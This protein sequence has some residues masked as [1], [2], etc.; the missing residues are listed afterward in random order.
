MVDRNATVDVTSRSMSER[1]PERRQLTI[2]FCDLVNST[3]LAEGLDP[4]DYASLLVRYRKLCTTVVERAGGVI[5]NAFGDGLLIYFGYPTASDTAASNALGA[6]LEIVAA[7][8][9]D[10]PS[11][12]TPD[13]AELAVRIGIHTGVVVIA[14]ALDELSVEPMTIFGSAPSIAARVQAEASPNSV[15]LSEATFQLSGGRV[16]CRELGVRHLRGVATPLRL[17]EVSAPAADAPAHTRSARS[18]SPLVGRRREQEWLTQRWSDVAAGTGRVLLLIGEPGIGKSH[19]GERFLEDVH[20]RHGRRLFARGS[21]HARHTAFAPLADMFRR[22]FLSSGREAERA[23]EAD[24]LVSRLAARNAPA[25]DLIAF[26]SLLALDVPPHL[27]AGGDRHRLNTLTVRALVRWLTE[28]ARQTPLALVVEDLHWADASTREVVT[29]LVQVAPRAPLLVLLTSRENIAELPADVERRTLRPLELAEARSL[30]MMQDGASALPSA[31]QDAILHRAAGNPLFIEELAKALHVG[32]AGALQGG[33]ALLAPEIPPTLRDTLTAR[34]DR[35]GAHKRVAQVA[36]VLGQRFTLALLEAMWE[37]PVPS[38]REGLEE[39]LRAELLVRAG[40][41]AE[42]AYA[43]R[44]ALIV[45]A[46]YASLL[47]RDRRRHHARAADALR[48]RSGGD[49]DFRPEQVAWHLSG[50]GQSE[51]AFEAWLAAAKASSERSAHAEATSQL[52]RAE[53]E[54]AK[55]PGADA[56]AHAERRLRMKLA[57]APVLIAR[58]GWAAPEVESAYR[59]ALTACDALDAPPKTRFAALRGL[60]NVYLLRGNLL[61]AQDI[62]QQ[63]KQL[64]TDAADPDLIVDA[65]RLPGVCRFLEADFEGAVRHLETVIR[66][67]DHEEMS[68]TTQQHGLQQMAVTSAWRAWSAWFQGD[69]E[70]VAPR[71]DEAAR[72]AREHQFS[73]A[74]VL[75]FAATA[76]QFDGDAERVLEWGASARRV[77]DEHGF[78]YWQAWA[79]I[80]TGWARSQRGEPAAGITLLKTG[81]ESYAG[82]GAAQMRG[83]WLCLLADACLGAWRPAEARTASEAAIAEA[84]RTGIGF[85]RPEAYRLL[86]EACLAQDEDR[87]AGRRALVSAVELALR[88][89]SPV[90][91]W[92]A[93]EATV[94]HGMGEAIEPL[95][96]R[97]TS[98]RGSRPSSNP[99]VARA[100]ASLHSRTSP[101]RPIG[102]R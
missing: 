98:D 101:A 28:E 74:Y 66:A 97:A 47:K 75:C 1:P 19:L 39:L 84:E 7:V 94:R 83:L 10:E 8:R 50:S 3:E 21:A 2:M 60:S 96:R 18:G 57:S 90:L 11:D 55:L 52:H 76:A 72:L 53:A 17:Y 20:A 89:G 26:A 41:A 25:E 22:E 71:L 44:H 16:P 102:S 70:T 82:L 99:T 30:L 92:K 78:A 9:G 65:H 59:A 12:S 100:L 43:F 31:T 40:T 61:E 95:L 81:M 58:K 38:L 37:G 42:P 4:E 73:R 33:E 56:A 80:V 85:F 46:A 77:A 51:A 63:I 23:A 87:D 88:Q 32:S 69:C 68:G 79:D 45:E 49:A 64:A 15:V 34:L 13:R 67:Y 14:D 54:L 5:A 36:S 93:A 27:Q 86:G 62:C 48:T 91:L 29:E 24:R 35:V 6:A